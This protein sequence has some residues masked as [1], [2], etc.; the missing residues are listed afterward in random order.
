[1]RADQYVGGTVTILIE[2]LVKFWP[3]IAGGIAAASTYFGIKAKGASD[4]RAAISAQTNKQA[5]AAAQEVRNVEDSNRQRSD[6]AV[7]DRLSKW[8]RKDPGVK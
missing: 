6:A 3:Y 8:V 4:A 2:L 7:Y 1:M 5:A